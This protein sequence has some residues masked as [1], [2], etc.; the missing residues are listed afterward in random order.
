MIQGKQ[1]LFI[2]VVLAVSGLGVAFGYGTG[3][4]KGKQG[5]VKKLNEMLAKFTLLPR[6]ESITF[7]RTATGGIVRATNP[8]SIIVESGGKTSDTVESEGKISEFVFAEDV[9]V[10]RNLVKDGRV[11]NTVKE[12]SVND[13]KEGETI[14]MGLVASPDGDV[15]VEKIVIVT[16]QQ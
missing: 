2:I 6:S 11:V 13:I 10:E 16:P 14:N 7:W 12:L 3:A 4:E 1:I 15:T 8:L 9:T 5:E